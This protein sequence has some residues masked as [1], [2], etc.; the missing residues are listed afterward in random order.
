[1]PE[2]I[3]LASGLVKLHGIWYLPDNPIW[4]CDRRVDGQ[5]LTAEAMAS[6]ASWGESKWV[7]VNELL[8]RYKQADIILDIFPK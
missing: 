5:T 4:Y 1:M 8:C 7:D 6:Y 2:C 3:S